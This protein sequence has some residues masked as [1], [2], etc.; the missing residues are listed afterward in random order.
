LILFLGE[1]EPGKERK[2]KLLREKKEEA[3]NFDKLGRKN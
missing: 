2:K 1:D 3:K